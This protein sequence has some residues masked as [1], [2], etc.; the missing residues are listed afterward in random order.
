MGYAELVRKNVKAAFNA[1]GNLAIDVTLVK[2]GGASFDFNSG[3][4]ED[5]T[6][7]SVCAR[8]IIEGVKKTS[9]KRNVTSKEMMLNYEEVGD[10]TLFDEVIIDG[11]TWKIGN[12]IEDDGFTVK[13]EIYKE[14]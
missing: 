2:S 1:V 14:V 9:E 6:S 8:A 11:T 4:S 7:S 3:A 10:I 12:P 5:V 13:A